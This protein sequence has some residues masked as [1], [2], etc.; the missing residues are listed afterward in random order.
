MCNKNVRSSITGHSLLFPS[1]EYFLAST[2]NFWAPEIKEL[3]VMTKLIW[4]Q[5]YNS[6]GK[7][8][9]NFIHKKPK[10]KIHFKLFN[11]LCNK[12]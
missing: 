2:F 11:T 12:I 8:S 7:E 10:N 5:V 1:I 4:L 9:Y 6:F 3:V